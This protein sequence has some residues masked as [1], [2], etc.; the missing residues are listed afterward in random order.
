MIKNI[1]NAIINIPL[2][3]DFH[4]QHPVFEVEV[5]QDGKTIYHNKTYAVIMNLVQSVTE[6]NP[7]TGIMEGDSQILCVGHP[8]VQLFAEDQLKKKMIASG[9]IDMAI[10]MLQGFRGTSIEFKNTLA[11][12][13]KKNSYKK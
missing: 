6:L 1:P 8:I 11:S 5:K 13:A 12:I 2:R 3:H 10:K 4:D 7:K 9:V